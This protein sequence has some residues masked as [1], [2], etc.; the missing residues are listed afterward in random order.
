M[1]RMI[2]SLTGRVVPVINCASFMHGLT[3]PAGRHLFSMFHVGL[4][5]A[6]IQNPLLMLGELPVNRTRAHFTRRTHLRNLCT[7]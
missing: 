6:F 3:V 5:L 4:L 7:S 2:A 1:Q